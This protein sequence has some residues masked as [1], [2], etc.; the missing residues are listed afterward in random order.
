MIV[1]AAAL[2][3]EISTYILCVISRDLGQTVAELL[4]YLPAGHVL[5]AFVQY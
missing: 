4:E 3:L 2:D 1:R 5:C